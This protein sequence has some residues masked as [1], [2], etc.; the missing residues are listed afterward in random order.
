MRLKGLKKD[1]KRKYLEH[2]LDYGRLV[3]EDTTEN[4]LRRLE[5]LNVFS[6][7][8]AWLEKFLEALD[9]DLPFIA[10]P[11]TVKVEPAVVRAG[12]KQ[13]PFE[14]Y[15]DK[16]F[17]FKVGLSDFDAPLRLILDAT[18]HEWLWQYSQDGTSHE[19]NIH[20]IRLALDYRSDKT[21]AGTNI[22]PTLFDALVNFHDFLPGRDL[23]QRLLTW[24]RQQ[25]VQIYCREEGSLRNISLSDIL[26]TTGQI[27]YD[28]D[29]DQRN[30]DITERLLFE[31]QRD[32]MEKIFHKVRYDIDKRQYRTGC[33][34]QKTPGSPGDF[35]DSYTVFFEFSSDEDRIAFEK[36]DKKNSCID[37]ILVNRGE[38]HIYEPLF[39]DDHA[40]ILR[41]FQLQRIGISPDKLNAGEMKFLRDILKY[42]GDNFSRDRREFYLM[43]NVES[44]RSI[45]IYLEGETRVFYPD[46]VLWIVDDKANKTT[47]VLLDPKGQTGILKE[48]DLGLS[49]SDAMNDKVRIASSGQ[50][51]ELANRL[52]METRRDWAIHSFILLRDSSPLGKFAGLVATTNEIKLAE[53]MINRKVLRLDWHQENEAGQRSSLLPN[54]ESYLTRIFS[55][56]Q[57][58]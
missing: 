37:G 31:V 19:G 53:K 9:K 47:M 8:K 3:N 1:G 44:L 30:W 22:S 33:V 17:T 32:L 52:S 6:L 34:R 26:Q 25:C 46:F 42:I 35:I 20:Q 12:K 45:G 40:E 13:I 58:N 16:L 50:L 18:T 24:S 36:K 4:K 41:R 7:K 11:Y 28:C 55:M 39:R 14:Q 29:L 27:L 49:S 54:D 38:F 56:I 5:T 10:G 43:R 57:Q 48:D 21:R 15:Q 23:R 51:R 2:C